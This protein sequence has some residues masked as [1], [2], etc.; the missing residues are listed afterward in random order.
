MAAQQ[1]LE[2]QSKMADILNKYGLADW[3][4]AA[5]AAPPAASC[6]QHRA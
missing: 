2:A 3:Q 4:N 5:T 6:K 1:S